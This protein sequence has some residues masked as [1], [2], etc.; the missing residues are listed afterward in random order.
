MTC[1]GICDYFNQYLRERKRKSALLTTSIAIEETKK[2]IDR[3]RDRMEMEASESRICIAAYKILKDTKFRLKV[4]QQLV[5]YDEP[6]K[7]NPRQKQLDEGTAEFDL[8][9]EEQRMGEFRIAQE[10]SATSDAAQL[11]HNMRLSLKQQTEYLQGIKTSQARLRNLESAIHQLRTAHSTQNY[12]VAMKDAS[13]FLKD[14]DR[15]ALLE[16]VTNVHDTLSTDASYGADISEKMAEGFGSV[17]ETPPTM[18]DLMK[19]LDDINVPEEDE[20]LPLLSFSSDATHTINTKRT[21]YPQRGHTESSGGLS[22]DEHS[23]YD[24]IPVPM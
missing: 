3:L 5:S 20:P 21:V 7:K 4:K 13:N 19:M 10:K 2:A 9:K 18:D 16:D 22:I 24:P 23:M 8:R 17:E 14:S 15:Q 6:S 11:E 12:V 1:F